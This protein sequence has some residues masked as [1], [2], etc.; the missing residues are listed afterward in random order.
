[1]IP[2]RG[3]ILYRSSHG[4]VEAKRPPGCSCLLDF[5]SIPSIPPQL[6]SSH[7][8]YIQ[9][10]EAMPQTRSALTSSAYIFKSSQFHE[11]TMTI[12]AATANITYNP[13]WDIPHPIKVIR[14][15][16]IAPTTPKHVRLHCPCHQRFANTIHNHPLTD[17]L[18][19]R[20]QHRQ[21][22][23]LCFFVFIIKI[24]IHVITGHTQY[25]PNLPSHANS[26][27]DTI[28]VM[29]QIAELLTTR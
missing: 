27:C 2:L 21:A 25:A 13:R 29:K 14:S 20:F 10:F 28:G 15:S 4:Y 23:L 11:G 1:M 12:A 8:P 22:L 6:F 9:K 7:H 17:L 18:V 16:A 26:L 5:R 19:Q 3:C 24:N